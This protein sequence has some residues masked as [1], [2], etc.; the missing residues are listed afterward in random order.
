MG[1]RDHAIGG[2]EC[3]EFLVCYSFRVQALEQRGRHEH[4]S[5]ARVL[6]PS[7]NLPQ[8]RGPQGDV[9]LTEPHLD[10]KTLKVVVE[11]QGGTLSVIPSVAQEEGS[12]ARIGDT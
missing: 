1:N 8:E 5:G 10:L 12:A 7:I 6:Q 9:S 4:D 11:I 2:E 3:G